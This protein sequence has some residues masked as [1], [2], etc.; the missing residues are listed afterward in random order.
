MQKN[1]AVVILGTCHLATTPGKKSTDGRLKEYAYGRELVQEI[2]QKLESYGYRVMVDY[3]DSQPCKEMQAATAKEQQSKELAYRVKFVN[4]ACKLFG[5]HNCIYVSVH[6]NA[7][8]YG[9]NWLS[10][11]GWSA[12]TSKG[13]TKA[14]RLA[15]C[16]YEA[17]ESNLK[18]YAATFP[19][20]SKQKPIRTD[21]SDGDKD[22]EAD[23]YVLR[24]T[25]C[26]AVLT[27]NMFMDNREDVAFL[28]S[29]AG[30]HALARLHVEGIL[31][32]FET[33]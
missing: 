12:Y 22:L 3:E 1:E 8:G 30:M 11:R 21:M 10:A 20:G 15:D 13:Q 27:E 29:D 23:L 5:A 4:A 28:L 32:Y 9:S 18:D 25:N 26:P 6:V 14:D 24:H 33:A 16:L 7:A 31:K 2:R 19:A 17:A